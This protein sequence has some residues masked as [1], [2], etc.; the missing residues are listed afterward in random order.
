MHIKHYVPIAVLCFGACAGS[1]VEP[2][3]R[4]AAKL[5]KLDGKLLKWAD[6]FWGNGVTRLPV[7]KGNV[8]KWSWY[9]AR[10]GNT[11]PGPQ[12]PFGMVSV[13][14]YSG[15]YPSGYGN[16]PR[17]RSGHAKPLFNG[18]KKARGFTH[19][20]QTGTGGIG[21]YYNFLQVTPTSERKPGT[22]FP[23][24]SV[25]DD[26]AY[27]GYYA[28]TLKEPN[29]RA[30]LTA[31]DKAAF[32]RYRFKSGDPAQLTVNLFSHG[33]PLAGKSMAITLSEAELQG[34][35]RLTGHL[36]H[37]DF[38][39]YFCMEV[40][41]DIA[42]SALFLGTSAKMNRKGEVRSKASAQKVDEIKTTFDPKSKSSE[43]KCQEWVIN[44]SDNQPVEVRVAFSYRSRE[45][46]IANLN[47]S[48]KNF[49]QALAEAENLWE[50]ALSRIP[51]KDSGDERMKELVYSALYHSLL[52][53]NISMDESPW[54]EDSAFAV[55]FSTLWD[56]YK[57]QLPL[58][59][60]YY[61]KKATPIIN[62]MI[63]TI[64]HCGY[65]PSGFMRTTNFTRFDG[66]T[67]GVA[68]AI[69]AF[70]HKNNIE[71]V[72]WDRA[73][74][75]VPKWLER[76]NVKMFMK[77]GV[78]TPLKETSITHTLDLVTAFSGI[79]YIAKAEGD[80]ALYN[81]LKGYRENWRNCYS[82]ETGLLREDS[83][84][85]EGKFTHY[86]F[87]P[88]YGMAE[89]VKLAGGK[90]KFTDML[91]DY[92]GFT[93]VEEGYVAPAEA[94]FVRLHTFEGLN[95]QVD[96]LSPWAYRWSNRPERYKEV[97]KG[98]FTYQFG[99]GVNGLPGNNDSGGLSAWV[100]LAAL[101]DMPLVEYFED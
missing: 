51:Y 80:L 85:Y 56:M 60:K 92:F 16:N 30:E 24:H 48:P 21:Y 45:Q 95:N 11:H 8:A 101:G 34:N 41:G 43:N 36:I 49:D 76:P 4:D 100:V 12:I 46:A 14:A 5:D 57:T 72:D 99:L 9:K 47:A 7:P 64:E 23:L 90:E 50:D 55:D 63:R 18:E 69:L 27:P 75:C 82:T 32:H 83:K 52:K 19:F 62:S 35:N 98:A 25:E 22:G 88:H 77:D 53:P 79:C 28:C 65:F 70:A 96:L 20:Q 10:T 37:G 97:I 26:I 42:S 1:A 3:Q 58:M 73:L 38:P 84:F 66:Q 94:K 59:I 87:R 15:A 61:P 33:L 91:D 93:A 29:V 31:S 78:V 81:K 17:S 89:R 74:K 39:Y 54:W 2:G 68:W 40:K 71:G 6:P 44:F 86:S 67:S 13:T